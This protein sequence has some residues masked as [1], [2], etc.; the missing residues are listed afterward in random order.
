MTPFELSRLF[1]SGDSGECCNSC[2]FC[3]S[4]E[5]CESGDSGYSGESVDS[6]D[7]ELLIFLPINFIKSSVLSGEKL[8][9]KLYVMFVTISCI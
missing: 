3:D 8:N 7:S 4:G 6:G 5:F 9:N 1:E 2:E